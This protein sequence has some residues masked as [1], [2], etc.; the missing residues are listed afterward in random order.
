MPA[1]RGN[2]KEEDGMEISSSG[3]RRRGK[4][5]QGITGASTSEK[6]IK[7]PQEGRQAMAGVQGRRTALR[8]H[9]TCSVPRVCISGSTIHRGRT[10][11][12]E[13]A[14]PGIDQSV[15]RW[16]YRYSAADAQEQ[17]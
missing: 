11:H 4:R 16:R 17:S 7:Y 14:T 1:Q 8:N 13:L 2:N 15:E 9:C 6:Y 12:T 3:S 10:M 5:T